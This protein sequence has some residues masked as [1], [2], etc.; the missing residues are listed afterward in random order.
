[1]ASNGDATLLRWVLIV[2][3]AAFLSNEKPVISLYE[4]NHVPDLHKPLSQIMNIQYGVVAPF[5]AIGKPSEARRRQHRI[6][7]PIGTASN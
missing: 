5:N 2:S 6:V 7:A 1:M 3:V 4:L